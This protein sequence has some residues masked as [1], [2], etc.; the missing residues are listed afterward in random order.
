ML[1]CYLNG[2]KAGM[3]LDSG[4][5]V[6]ILAKSWLDKHLTNNRIES[7]GDLLPDNLL[8]IT[9]TK[10]T[11]VPFEGWVKVLVEIKSA[12]HGRVA[13]IVLMLVSQSC[14]SGVFLGFN[15]IEEIILE[16]GKGRE[17]Q[18]K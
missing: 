11:D 12:K 14:V 17:C 6:T 2:V 18:F 1:T 5:Q 16:F 10:G 15:V 3:L 4:T 7:P 8:K 9:A 13:L